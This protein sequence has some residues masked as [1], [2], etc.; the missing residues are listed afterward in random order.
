VSPTREF[1]DIQT[2]DDCERL[3]RAFYGRALEDPIIGWIFTDVARLDLEEHVPVLTA[4][5]E[6]LLL[7]AQTY[8]GRGAFAPHADLHARVGLQA[9][10]FERWLGLWYA[11]VDEL[12]AGPTAEL[13]KAHAFRLSS[14]FRH[15]L[16][17]YASAR[18][19]PPAPGG[20]G[21]LVVTRHGDADG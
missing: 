11:T 18:D 10:H 1:R 4:F 20:A 8:V 12:Y 5:W 3:V 14:A 2:R 9:G 13:A 17:A 6:T 19:T 7:G 16:Q 21:G 15:R